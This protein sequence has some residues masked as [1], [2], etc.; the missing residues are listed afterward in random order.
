MIRDFETVKKEFNEY[1]LKF[2]ESCELTLQ[3]DQALLDEESFEA[4]K[5]VLIKRSS[6]MRQIYKSNDTL[7]SLITELNSYELTEEIADLEYEKLL[8]LF[9]EAYDDLFIM[10]M[11]AEHILPFYEEKKD[12]EKMLFL[13]HMLGFEYFEFFGRTLSSEGVKDTVTY[14]KKIISLIDHYE[15]IEDPDRRLVFF[16]AYDNLI[17]P[18]G[19]VDEGM[20]AEMFTNYHAAMD[21][22]NSEMVQ[23]LDGDNEKFKASIVQIDEDV[24]YSEDF[25]QEMPEDYQQDFIKVVEDITNR[26]GYDSEFNEEGALFRANIKVSLL[27]NME[28]D[29][30]INQAIDRINSIA[31][32]DFTDSDKAHNNLLHIL[33]SHD[34]ACT[35]FDIFNHYKIDSKNTQSYVK[36]FVERVT[37]FHS[38][39]PL[40]FNT[41]MI[42][43]LCFEWFR[44]ISKYLDDSEYEKKLLLRLVISRQPLTYIHSLMVKHIS[45]MISDELYVQTPEYYI[46]MPGLNS[47]DDVHKYK[48]NL[49][50]Y[51]SQAALLHDVGKCKMVEVIN[52]QNRRLFDEEFDIIQRHPTSGRELLL[53]DKSFEPY[54]DVMIGHHKFYDGTKGYPRDFNN[55]ESP[56]KKVIDIITIADCTDAATD[57][58][59][60]NYTTGKDFNTLMSELEEGSGTRYNPD[61]VKLIRNTPKLYDALTYVTGEGRENVYFNAFREI[62]YA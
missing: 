49:L 48:D 19:Q 3:Y 61:I 31:A 40:G 11:M 37:S 58:L 15:E 52:R 1:L 7:I 14:Y 5:S 38:R 9:Y 8:V 39:V 59:G 23:R 13:Y 42:N 17:A 50:N 18:T 2:T 57:I 35:V 12:Y 54:Y 46:G 32:P 26:Y 53:N 33:D 51:I 30:L 36:R 27:K 20:K 55:L 34:T 4:W 43:E 22:W 56:V 25:V 16:K 28:P 45:E 6:D 44:E 21:L 41:S 24:L 10:R 62:I 29:A 60:R 47:V